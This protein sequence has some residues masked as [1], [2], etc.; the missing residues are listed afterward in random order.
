MSPA[1]RLV[2]LIAA[3]LIVGACSDYGHLTDVRRPDDILADSAYPSIV[4]HATPHALEAGE[5]LMATV[6]DDSRVS[7]AVAFVLSQER[8]LLWRS[9]TM[10][11]NAD[12]AVVHFPLTNLP[13]NFPFSEPLLWTVWA[14]DAA[15]KERYAGADDDSVALS[16]ADAEAAPLTVVHGRTFR[17]AEGVDLGGIAYDAFERLLYFTVPGR[18]EVRGL[19]LASMEL[20]NWRIPVGSRP[21]LIAFQRYAW[22][23]KPV[24]AV[25]NDGGTDVSVVDL[26]A[27]GNGGS[28]RWRVPIPLIRVAL[29]EDTLALRAKATSLFIHCPDDFCSDPVLY[30]GS[31]HVGGAS[32]FATRTLAIAD[33]DP[34]AN[35]SVFAPE[36]RPNIIPDDKP[37][38]IEAWAVDPR[39]GMESRLLAPVTAS[40]CGTLAIGTTHI[41]APEQF[42]G[43]LFLIEDGNAR[44]ACGGSGRVLRFSRDAFGPYYISTPAVINFDFDAEL[45]GV[46]QVAT[47]A[48]GSLVLLRS[49]SN[50]YVTTGDLRRL[51]TVTVPGASGV[52]F[53]EGQAGG[54]GPLGQGALFAVASDEGIH[55]FETA[56]FTELVHYRT[57]RPLGGELLFLRPGGGDEL[58]ILGRTRDA[59]GILVVE[60][61][62]SALRVM[63]PD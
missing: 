50:V 8:K 1:A 18:N 34:N 32:R 27:R 26:S 63:N 21:G 59:D 3:P 54:T 7:V 31:P 19:S 38:V 14:R 56:H 24:L 22:G 15:D 20:L 28:E 39:T 23:T 41:T 33:V 46:T 9:D 17:I 42:G 37:I 62:L 47:N 36:Y 29:G 55:V 5:S 6:T 49:G 48:D 16:L 35:F 13:P 45:A 25:F 30:F 40:R 12:S 10:H 60:S 51:G 11:V 52:A 4:L 53:L 58:Q 57:A 61:R 43:D 2:T 44:G